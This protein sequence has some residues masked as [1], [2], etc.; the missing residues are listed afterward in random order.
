[1]HLD[2]PTPGIKPMQ[3]PPIQL[4]CCLLAIWSVLVLPLP[5]HAAQAVVVQ[6]INFGVVRKQ[7]FNVGYSWLN[8]MPV[9]WESDTAWV[10][11][12]ESLDPNLGGSDDGSYTKSLDDL[13]FKLHK[14]TGNRWITMLEQPQVLDEGTNTGSGTIYVD[15]RM[16]LSWTADRP[17]LYG[18]T[19]LFT[20]SEM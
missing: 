8:R 19:L 9:W 12:V 1:M 18:T 7:D 4:A 20:I 11:T 6:D 10:I 13:E 16:L 14:A 17:G 5:A 3:K 2:K 15:W